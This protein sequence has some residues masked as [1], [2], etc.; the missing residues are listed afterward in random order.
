[1]CVL[2]QRLE[3]HKRTLDQ[4]EEECKLKL[5]KNNLVNQQIVFRDV[6]QKIYHKN[7]LQRILRQ[8]QK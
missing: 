2:N 4:I 3:R 7:L 8:L 1:M 6:L 5:K